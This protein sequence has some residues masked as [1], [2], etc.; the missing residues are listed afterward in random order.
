MAVV[1]SLQGVDEAIHHLNIKNKSSLKF[2]L[3]QEIRQ[4]YKSDELLE[5][6]AFIDAKQIIHTLWQVDDNAAQIKNKRK[7]LSAIK[8]SMND[9]LKALYRSGQNPQGIIIGPHNTFVM[10]DDAKNAILSEVSST[11]SSDA[12]PRAST[13]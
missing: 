1:I 11:R 4:N 3:L 9:E 5:T 10:C 8:W 2:R 7:N 13:T 12:Q 6:L